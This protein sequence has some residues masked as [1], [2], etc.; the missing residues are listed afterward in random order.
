MGE[1]GKAYKVLAENLQQRIH[2]EDLGKDGKIIFRCIL[3][4]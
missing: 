4:K 1:K 2:L 3:K